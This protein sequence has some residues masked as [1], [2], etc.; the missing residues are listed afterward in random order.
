MLRKQI[1]RERLEFEDHFQRSAFQAVLALTLFITASYRT[2]ESLSSTRFG[3]LPLSIRAGL[4]LDSVPDLSQPSSTL[5]FL[6][7][8]HQ[9]LERNFPSIAGRNRGGARAGRSLLVGPV[10]LYTGRA[11][12]FNCILPE[13]SFMHALIA[14][15]ITTVREDY[16][17][18]PDYYT[19]ETA[20]TKPLCGETQRVTTSDVAFY[21]MPSNSTINLTDPLL[22]HVSLVATFHSPDVQVNTVLQLQIGRDF[23]SSSM[24][25]SRTKEG[26]SYKIDLTC[27]VFSGLNSLVDLFHLFRPLENK[28]A[29]TS[30]LVSRLLVCTTS[31]GSLMF[32]SLAIYYSTD[33][34]LPG[35]P[36]IDWPFRTLAT[37][38]PELPGDEASLLGAFKKVLEN[39]DT[40][41]WFDTFAILVLWLLLLRVVILCSIHPHLS[42]FTSTLTHGW[43][44]ISHFLS[45]FGLLLLGFAY[46]Y[47]YDTGQPFLGSLEQ[48]FLFLMGNWDVEVTNRFY[49]FFIAAFGLIMYFTGLFIV[50]GLVSA[51]YEVY[52]E[53]ISRSRYIV[54]SVFQDLWLLIRQA[55]AGNVHGW[56][57]RRDAIRS[58]DSN[59][60]ENPEM[61]NSGTVHMAKWYDRYVLPPLEAE[62][63]TT[64]SNTIREVLE[65]AVRGSNVQRRDQLLLQEI[66]RIQGHVHAIMRKII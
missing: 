41:V 23:S 58:I 21:F 8:T 50:L 66:R 40:L 59:A 43:D 2:F 61:M 57:S 1:L 26:A 19:I 5:E 39:R 62:M 54:K 4:R 24:E 42:M 31:L 38:S 36:Q 13:D 11:R 30:S 28:W 6:T 47:H 16:G 25:S 63:D 37:L 32:F 12:S 22:A 44:D 34:E 46:I 14:S 35:I 7:V 33:Y 48:Q 27:L 45:V 56:P 15:N 64:D 53:Q 60:Y 9:L 49:N 55:R 17:Y 3:E 52:L 20:C 65:G 18:C 51:A 29:Q 10:L